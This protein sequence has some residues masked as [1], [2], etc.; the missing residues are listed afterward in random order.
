ML[1]ASD[2][3]V[4]GQVLVRLLPGYQLLVVVAVHVA[5]EIPGGTGPLGHGVGL[6]LG[7]SAADRAGGVHPL[8]DGSQR[9]LAGAGG[10]VALHLRQAQGQLVL[11]NRH[12]AA[13]G[14]V[15]D[16]D[17]LAPVALAGEYPVA[18]LVVHRLVS[19]ALLLDHVG[20][21][22]FQYRGLHAV[23]VAGIDHHAAGLG[24][25]LGHVLDLLAVLGDDL[26]DGQSELLGK[27]KVAVVVGGHAHDR[28]GAVVRQ[29]VIG[30]P[31][32]R[33]GPV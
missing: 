31:D 18:Q 16:R 20:G 14:A 10:L 28:A 25:S 13:L 12:A 30:Q 23:P 29:H 1:H 19:K 21:F 32:G 22:L 8:V 11:G 4:H 7:R 5:Q 15:D 6:P 27:F 33:L 26:H 3:H 24:I 9:G 17:R 2:I